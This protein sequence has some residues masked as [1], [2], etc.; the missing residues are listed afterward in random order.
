MK[1]AAKVIK[2]ADLRNL[3]SIKSSLL[4]YICFFPCRKIISCCGEVVLWRARRP[5]KRHACPGVWYGALYY[6]RCSRVLHEARPAWLVSWLGKGRCRVASFI[7]V[8]VLNR[9]GSSF[10]VFLTERH[11][12][13]SSR[14]QDVLVEN[15]CRIVHHGRVSVAN[16]HV[17]AR[18]AP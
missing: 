7:V 15:I 8:C 17:A 3:C 2:R 12:E 14:G 1:C 4:T 5:G 13:R 18:F 10:Q 6:I 11:P 9:L 16:H